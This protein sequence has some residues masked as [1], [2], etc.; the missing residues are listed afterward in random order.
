MQRPDTPKTWTAMKYAL[1]KN[2]KEPNF[3][4]KIRSAIL[5]IKQRGSYHGYVA[6]FQEQLPLVRLEP[7]FAKE[8]FLKGLTSASLRKQ[9]LRKNPASL[10]GLAEEALNGLDDTKPDAAKIKPSVEESDKRQRK[11]KGYRAEFTTGINSNKQKC[12]FCGVGYHEVEGCRVKFPEKKPARFGKDKKPRFS[13]RPPSDSV[14]Y[15]AKYYALVD[16]LLIDDVNSPLS[17]LHGP[18]PIQRDKILQQIEE[19]NVQLGDYSSSQ[20]FLTTQCTTRKDE[21]EISWRG[22]VDSGATINAVTPHFI[23][24]NGLEDGIVSHQERLRLTMADRSTATQPKRTIQLSFSLEGFPVYEA[25]FLILEV[26]G[27]HDAL[28]GKPENRLE[29]TANSTTIVSDQDSD[30]SHRQSISPSRESRRCTKEHR[31]AFYSIDTK[32]ISSKQFCRML[33]KDKDIEYVF[34][35]QPLQPEVITKATSIDDYKDYSIYPYL[36]KYNGLFRQKLPEHLPPKEHGEHVMNAHSEDL[37]FR[38]QW[39]QSPAQEAEIRRWKGEMLAVGITSSECAKMVFHTRAFR[40]PDGL[41][42]YFV[43]PMGLSNAP[44]TFNA[45]IRAV[46]TDLQ[47]FCQSYFDN[48]YTKSRNI[49]DHLGALD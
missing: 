42:E 1:E 22:F 3:Q 48:I 44:A 24:K 4:Q 14:D 17:P 2:I 8:V 19:V 12:T 26:P 32:C 21:F 34:V 41:F 43:V 13:Q 49:Q 46:L 23:L 35:V 16:K 28:L 45:G 10:E 15:K 6:K 27:D 40:T 29:A 9:I 11:A 37:I 36:R 25:V 7:I 39:R 33:Q 38:P 31:A 5:N 18:K 20:S 30:V 47:D